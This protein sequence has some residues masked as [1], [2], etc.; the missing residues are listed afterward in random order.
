MREALAKRSFPVPVDPRQFPQ[1]VDPS[2]PPSDLLEPLV[3]GLDL[4]KC[5]VGVRKVQCVVGVERGGLQWPKPCGPMEV[6]VD[7]GVLLARGPD[8]TASWV[9]ENP[10]DRCNFA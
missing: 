8:E 5:V 9:V 4:F 2:E 1:P 6:D 3:W 7:W 10:T